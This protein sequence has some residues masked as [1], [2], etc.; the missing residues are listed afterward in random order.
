MQPKWPESGLDLPIVFEYSSP[1]KR[2]LVTHHKTFTELAPHAARWND[3][4]GEIPFRRWEWLESWWRHYG[5]DMDGTTREKQL[6]LLAVREGNKI[7]GIAPWYIHRLW[8]EGRTIRWLGSGEVC[9]EYHSLLCEPGFEERVSNVIAHWLTDQGESAASDVDTGWDVMELGAIEQHD[10]AMLQLARALEAAGNLVQV[11]SS[12][13]C[14]RIELPQQWDEF[15]GRLSKSHRKQV[16][17]SE[18]RLLRSGRVPVHRASNVGELDRGFDVLVDLHQRR[19]ESIGQWGSFHSH[20][21]LEFHRE[22]IHRLFGLQAADLYWL[23]CDGRPIAAEYHVLGG[24]TVYAYQSGI[25]PDHLELEPGRLAV[26]ATIQQ[27]IADRR[28]SY[29]FLRGDESYKAHWRAKPKAVLDFEVV[30]ARVAA[31]LRRRVITAG[32]S[33]RSWIKQGLELTGLR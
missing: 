21:F 23:E 33:V 4:S 28:A 13:N 3:L 9:T 20:R 6:L 10:R 18:R 22:V 11:T 16:R 14:W 2:M 8:A 5:L 12:K 7:V 27:A 19:W 15:L 30:P 29:D 25:A 31:R 1:A 24:R 32:Q 17:R 26:L